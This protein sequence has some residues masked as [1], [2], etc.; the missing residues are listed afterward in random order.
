MSV[1]YTLSTKKWLFLAV[2]LSGFLWLGGP[3]RAADAAAPDKKTVRLWKANC[4]SCHGEDGKAKTEQGTKMGVGDMT[5]PEFWKDITDEKFV[6][7]VNDGFKRKK[8][9][10]DQEMK[11][12]K[13]KLKPEQ[14]EA[15]RAY[16]RSLK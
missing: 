15:L 10:K 2:P 1:T 11:G 9:G 14:V 16:A 6:K 13:A 7:A 5:K 4:A 8:N 3:A 12:L